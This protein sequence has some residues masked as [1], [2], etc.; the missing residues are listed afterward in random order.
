VLESAGK[1]VREVKL[2]SEPEALVAW[3]RGLDAPLT[4][5]GLEAG[6]LSQW[7]YAGLREAGFAVELLETR[8]VADAFRSMPVKTD[9]KDARGI[10]Q[11][12][13]LGWFKPV[14]CKSLGAQEA[15]A[16]LTARRQV[17]AKRHDLE[18]VTVDAARHDDPLAVGRAPACGVERGDGNFPQRFDLDASIAGVVK[19]L[20]VH[21]GFGAA[22]AGGWKL[23]VVIKSNNGL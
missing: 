20:H 3:F 9:R 13:R 11:L 19:R 23:A 1:V 7:L 8:Q 16:L 17:Q 10:A 4:R 22:Q 18:I 5:L 15:R 12:L 21:C 6:P 14:H 2:A